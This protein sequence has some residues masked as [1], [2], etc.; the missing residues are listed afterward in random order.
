VKTV[1]ITGAAGF[2][3]T[4]LTR[5]LLS[6]GFRVIGLD[7]FYSSSLK[8][9]ALFKDNPK[10]KLIRHDIRRPIGIKDK[11]DEIYNLACPASPPIYQK[12]PI[13]TLETSVLGIRNVL[14]MARK[15]RAKI[16]QASTSEVYGNPLEHPQKESYWG[17]VNTVGPRSCY[18]EGKRVAET[19]CFEYFNRGVDVRVIRIFNTYGPYMNPKDGRVVVN[20]VNQALNNQDLTVYGDGKQTRSFCFV[21]DLVEGMVKYMALKKRFLGPLNLGNPQE[22]TILQLAEAILKLIPRSKSK[23]VYKPLPKDDPVKRKPDISQAKKILNW[24]PTVGLEEG[25][26]KTIEYFRSGKAPV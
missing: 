5:R 9:T 16:L 25:L 14:G 22:K 23:I 7:N 10:Y 13:F 26:K 20:F 8:N 6:L 19:F 21:D 17:N 24:Q 15:H 4:N 3:G 2:I 1:L 12:D 18:D 11:I